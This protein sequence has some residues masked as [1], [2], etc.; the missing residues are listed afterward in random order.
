VQVTFDPARLSYSDLLDVF[1]AIHDPQT[2]NRQGGDVGTQYRSAIFPQTEIQAQTAQA[3]I[4]ELQ[5]SFPRPIVT[6][7]EPLTTFYPAEA[8]HRSY[9]Q[10]HPTQP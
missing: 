5:P 8:Y 1:F 3:K 10:A 4:A 7:I 6:Q 2:L 9:Y